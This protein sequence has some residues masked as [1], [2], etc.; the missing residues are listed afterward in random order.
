[1]PSRTWAVPDGLGRKDGQPRRLRRSRRQTGLANSLSLSGRGEIGRDQL[2]LA[3]FAAA[4]GNIPRAR[5]SRSALRPPAAIGANRR[6]Q[7]GSRAHSQGGP[8]PVWTDNTHR[9]SP[10]VAATESCSCTGLGARASG[11]SRV[12]SSTPS[13]PARGV[14]F[15]LDAPRQPAAEVASARQSSAG[16]LCWRLLSDGFLFTGG[17]RSRITPGWWTKWCSARRSC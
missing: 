15:R 1:V 7:G 17:C 6:R 16:H 2:P 13:R 5:E 12:S 9:P 10:S 4:P 14:R 3:P 11:A 8:G